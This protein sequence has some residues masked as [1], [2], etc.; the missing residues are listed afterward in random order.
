MNIENI[1]V[2]SSG[3][4]YVINIASLLISIKYDLHGFY[5]VDEQFSYISSELESILL[6]LMIKYL[7]I[8]SKIIFP[9][10]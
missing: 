6:S 2:L 4:K 1:E 5:Y 9:Y 8:N 7:P 10:T 3:T